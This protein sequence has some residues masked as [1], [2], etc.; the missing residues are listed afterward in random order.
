[1]RKKI[2]F[3]DQFGTLGGGQQVLLDTLSTLDTAQF[4]PTVALNGDGPFRKLLLSRKTRVI[5][6]PL[7]NYHSRRK[8]IGD[9]ARFGQ[10]TLRCSL[11]LASTVL[12]N[13]FDL[14]FANGPRTFACG[15]LAGR[16]T[17]RPVIW[18]LH[19]VLSSETA[20]ALSLMAPWVNRVIACSRAAA[21]PLIKHRPGLRSRIQLIRNPVPDWQEIEQTA[22][23]LRGRFAPEEGVV[24]FG[25]LGRV[26][27]FKGQAQFIKAAQIVLQHSRKVRFLVIGS[28]APDDKEDQ[29]YYR[30]LRNQVEKSRIE[31]YVHFIEHENEVQRCYALLDAVVMASQGNEA[32]PRTLIEAMYLGKP[33]LAPSQG[34]IPEILR[35]DETGLLMESAEPDVLAGRML[36][37]LNDSARRQILGN[38]AKKDVRARFSRNLFQQ[39]MNK[40]LSVCIES[41]TRVLGEQAEPLV[42]AET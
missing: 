25:V 19:N 41:Q 32:S 39:E 37:L 24:F 30:E 16:L 21:E 23:T 17:G 1:M 14:I 33:V 10:R 11:Y 34:G 2:L 22:V 8:T 15:A 42:V 9:V 4:D 5:D 36:E 7:G 31:S 38:A 3:L 20:K 29:G 13:H 12:R 18:H 6:L 28:P 26:T 40:A 27:P 35:D